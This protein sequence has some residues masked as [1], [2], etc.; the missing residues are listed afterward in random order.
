MVNLGENLF[1]KITRICTGQIW[2][3]FLQWFTL[4]RSFQISHPSHIIVSKIGSSLFYTFPHSILRHPGWYDYASGETVIHHFFHC[5]LSRLTLLFVRNLLELLF[6]VKHLK[7]EFKFNLPK[8][9]RA[10]DVVRLG[11]RDQELD[12]RRNSG[13]WYK[14]ASGELELIIFL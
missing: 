4:M 9:E 13:V 1:K 3:N 10:G 11:A 8:F 5:F 14:P 12:C 7:W 2:W 6:L